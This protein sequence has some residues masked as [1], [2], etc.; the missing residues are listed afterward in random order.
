M[1]VCVVKD[2]YG[3]IL[4]HRVMQNETDDQIAVPMIEATKK[5]FSDFNSCIFDKGFHSPEN[6]SLPTTE[7][8]LFTSSSV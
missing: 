4:H 6:G 3:F 7:N 8:S 1:K 2:Q 5:R